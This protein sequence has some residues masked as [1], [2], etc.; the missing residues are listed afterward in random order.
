MPS[1]PGAFQ[2]FFFAATFVRSSFVTTNSFSSFT[3]LFNF[4]LIHFPPSS[5][6]YLAS[7]FPHPYT[8][9]KFHKFSG[10]LPFWVLSFSSILTKPFW[11][12]WKHDILLFSFLLFNIF[13][14]FNLAHQNVDSLRNKFGT[15]KNIPFDISLISEKKI[16]NSFPNSQFPING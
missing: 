16:D 12:F 13:E 15:M 8:S 3:F 5:L 9:P 2:F 11:F 1:V 7:F 6:S 4:V 10:I 14:K